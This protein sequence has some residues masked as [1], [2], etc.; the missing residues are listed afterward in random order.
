MI[1][2]Q[3]YDYAALDALALAP[4]QSSNSQGSITESGNDNSQ[5]SNIECQSDVRDASHGELSPK[6]DSEEGMSEDEEDSS[7]DGTMTQNNHRSTND[8]DD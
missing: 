8:V 5:G 3:T 7:H 4:Q 6:T 2:S 1:P